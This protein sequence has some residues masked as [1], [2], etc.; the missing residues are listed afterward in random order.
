VTKVPDGPSDRTRLALT[1]HLYPDA[2][3]RIELEFRAAASF[4]PSLLPLFGVGDLIAGTLLQAA[5][6]ELAGS[7][8]SQVGEFAAGR[9]PPDR[10]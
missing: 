8:R 2:A 4:L 10:A 7:E 3:T 5:A 1:W 9:R 6:R